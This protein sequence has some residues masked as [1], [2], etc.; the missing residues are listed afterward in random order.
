[1]AF[2]QEQIAKLKAAAAKAKAELAAMSAISIVAPTI[3]HL[4]Y[5]T[6]IE[7]I[8]EDEDPIIKINGHA[9]ETKNN[10]ETYEIVVPPIQLP[11]AKAINGVSWNQEQEQAI[12]FGKRGKSFVLIGAAGTGKTTTLKGLLLELMNNHLIQPLRS[13]SKYLATGAPGIVLVSY[14]RRAV[15]QIARQMPPELKGHCL[16]IHKLLEYEPFFYEYED[17]DGKIKKTMRFEPTKNGMNPLPFE[18]THVVIDESSMVATDLYENLRAALPRHCQ[19]IFLGDLHQL[20]PVY[21]ESVLANKLQELPVVELTRVYR[22]ALD[23]PIIRL[24]T[25]IKEGKAIPLKMGEKLRWKSPDEKSMVVINAWPKQLTSEDAADAAANQMKML[26]R[27]NIFNE[28]E[29]VILMP[30]NK[31]ET[32]RNAFGARELNLNIANE[33]GKKR[34][35][36][37]HH[38]ISGFINW[39]LAIG[40]R[41]LIDKQDC[42]IRDISINPKYMGKPPVEPSP[43]LDRWGTYQ[44]DKTHHQLETDNDSI[45][46]LMEKMANS[47]VDDKVNQSSHVLKIESLDSGAIWNVSETGTINSMVFSYALTVHKSQGSEWR[48]VFLFLHSSHHT[49][50]SREL[51]YT[52]VTRAREELIILCEPDR[53]DSAGTLTRAA[54]NPRIKGD[55]LAEKL[56]WLKERS[57]ERLDRKLKGESDDV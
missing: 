53:R 15:R 19:F 41:L 25:D 29:D 14:T 28:E 39:Y 31:S 12:T 22:Q 6:P 57:K 30:Q 43:T 13:G 42:I 11:V 7:W 51:V 45:D 56:A 48:R 8:K 37:V 3:N 50:C 46:A 16:T 10:N 54:R 4:P 44:D 18:L 47:S 32:L 35:A 23:S 27:E 40:D 52:A 34:G 24:A 21:G 20:P 33:L 17:S 38:V 36:T 1:M 5:I 26:I 9:K 49:M 2:T 55:T